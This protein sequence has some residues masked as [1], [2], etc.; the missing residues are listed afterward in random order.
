[1]IELGHDPE[2]IK[3]TRKLIKKRNYDIATLKN[4]LKIPQLH[5]PQTQEVLENKTRRKELMDLVLE[6]SDQL[7]DIE[8]ELEN[9]IQ[10]K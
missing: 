2:D 9:L 1:V 5:H 3:A 10:L 7:T 8:K 6:L 4:Q